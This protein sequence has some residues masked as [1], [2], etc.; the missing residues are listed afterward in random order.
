MAGLSKLVRPLL[1]SGRGQEAPTALCFHV[2]FT[3]RDDPELTME[4][5][6]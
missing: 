4:E 3:R 1:P 6:A 5:T 2:G